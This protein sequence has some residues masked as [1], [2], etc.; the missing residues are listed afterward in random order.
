M[1]PLA[2]TDGVLRGMTFAPESPVPSDSSIPLSHLGAFRQS[3]VVDSCYRNRAAGQSFVQETLFEIGTVSAVETKAT[4]QW[5]S[6]RKTLVRYPVV[7]M[8]SIY[9]KVLL[10]NLQKTAIVPDHASNRDVHA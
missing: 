5:M 3:E 2:E 1:L 4:V 10:A 6:P 8:C 7:V 9:P